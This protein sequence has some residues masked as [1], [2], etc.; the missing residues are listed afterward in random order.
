MKGQVYLGEIMNYLNLVFYI[1]IPIFLFIYFCFPAKYRYIVIFIGSYVFYGYAN[2]WMLLVLMGITAISYV[3]GILLDKKRNKIVFALTFLSEICVLFVFKYVKFVSS[4]INSL[5]HKLSLDI[6]INTEWN[7]ILPVGLSFI[8][9]QSCTYLSDVYRGNIKAEKNIVRYGA[10]VSYFPTVLSGPIQ[11]ARNLIPQITSPKQFEYEQAKKGTVLFVWGLFE[12]IIVANKLGYISSLILDEYQ[13]QSSAAILL[14]A[15]SFSIYI[16]A[17]FSSYSDMA[18]GISKIMGVEIGRNFNNPY[19]SKTTSEFWNRWH[20]SLNEW[21][22]ENVYIPLGGNRR[23][24]VRKYINMLIVFLLSGLWH[25]ANWHFVV[26]GIINGIFAI[27]GEIISPFKKWL[28]KKMKIKEDVESVIFF[29]RIIVFY[30]ITLTWMFFRTGVGDAL[31]IC[32]RIVLFD[33]L[34]IF[35]SQLLS[36]GGAP[37]ITFIALLATVFFGIVQYMRRDETEMYRKYTKQPFVVQSFSLAV[38]I[39]ICIFGLCST[40]ANVNTQ[41]L[42]FQ[43]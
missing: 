21:F 41:F 11:K 13:N 31:R 15:V 34:S 14:G 28:Y 7:I 3:G 24:K 18:R 5:V 25:G 33:F 8:V 43:F 20:M 4:I 12:K 2:I 10:F 37:G 38:V 17:D 1:F 26:W 9:F 42:Y 39:C 36:I 16:Y 30:L 27:V 35:N 6:Q 29:K 32:K 22:V 19:M 23:G 40:D